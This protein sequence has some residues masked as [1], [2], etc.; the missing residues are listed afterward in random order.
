M[1]VT[2]E[3]SYLAQI[4]FEKAADR[5]NDITA[6]LKRDNDNAEYIKELRATVAKLKLKVDALEQ[7]CQENRHRKATRLQHDYHMALA[8]FCAARSELIYQERGE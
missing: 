2:Q 1:N 5:I 7:Q 8:Q 6:E 4:D 3:R